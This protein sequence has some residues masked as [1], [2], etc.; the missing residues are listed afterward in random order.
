MTGLEFKRIR[1][2]KGYTQEQLSKKLDLSVSKISV[3]ERASEKDVKVVY[4]LAI[5]S[6]S[7]NDGDITARA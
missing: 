7:E 2:K 5:N 6:I 1:L 4:E 3:I